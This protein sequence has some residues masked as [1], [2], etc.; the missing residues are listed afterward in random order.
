MN[1]YIRVECRI[2]GNI[3]Y[4]QDEEMPQQIHYHFKERINLSINNLKVYPEYPNNICIH[5]HCSECMH[6]PIHMHLLLTMPWSNI[7]HQTAKSG[8]YKFVT[9][10]W[11]YTF[12]WEEG[13]KSVLLVSSCH[14][15]AQWNWWLYVGGN[16]SASLSIIYI[17]IG[18]LVRTKENTHTKDNR[19]GYLICFWH[20]KFKFQIIE[21]DYQSQIPSAKHATNK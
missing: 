5:S 6:C 12:V 10:G 16:G 11:S 4:T 13:A 2:I 3:I 18:G 9:I 15:E 7:I 8:G 17:D 19:G 1:N 14:R 20:I 21:K